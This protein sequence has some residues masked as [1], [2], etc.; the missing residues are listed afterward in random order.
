MLVAMLLGSLNYAN[1]L[2]LVL[3]FLLGALGVVAMHACHR[4][5]EALVVKAAGTE[6]PFAGHAAVFRIALANPGRAPRCDLEAVPA[7]GAGAEVERRGRRRSDGRDP[8][9]DAPSRQHRARPARD[10]DPVSL[11]PVSRLG[12]TASRPRLPRLSAAGRECAAAAARTG[13]R[14]RRQRASRRGRFRGAQ[15]LPP[16]RSAAAHRLEGVCARRRAPGQGVQ[17]RRRDDPDVRP[18]RRAGRGPRSAPVHARALDRRR[19]AP[20]A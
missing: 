9:A 5:L 13:P 16:G 4:N 18:R 7:T 15:G 6:P 20:A 1:N 2:G 14:R 8:R 10:R 12:R 3:T 17:R 19:A 11:R